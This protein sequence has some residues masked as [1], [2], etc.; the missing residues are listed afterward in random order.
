MFMVLV[1]GTFP[2]PPF[3]NYMQLVNQQLY[4]TFFIYAFNPATKY[5]PMKTTYNKRENMPKCEGTHV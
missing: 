3:F 2:S 4:Q 5:N 1:E